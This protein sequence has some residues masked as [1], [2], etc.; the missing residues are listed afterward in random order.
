MGLDGGATLRTRHQRADGSLA[1]SFGPGPRGA[2]LR[3]LRQVSPLRA[4]FPTPEPGENPVV[5]VVNTAGGVAGGDRLSVDLRLQPGACVTVSTPAAEKVYRALDASA[6]IALRLDVGPGAVLE[7]IPQETILFSGARLRRRADI[8]LAPDARLVLTDS[9]VLGRAAMG[10]RFASGSVG[11]AW[12]LRRGGRL[13]WADGL[14]L[15]GDLAP[16]RGRFGFAGAEAY[17]TLLLAAPGAEV[18]LPALRAALDG[19]P[20]GPPCRAPGCSLPA[21]WAARPQSVVRSRRACSACVP[22]R[23]AFRPA[24]RGCGRREPIGT[25]MTA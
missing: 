2:A 6:E 9:L 11:D 14:R 21:S 24:C 10:E 7:W 19:A 18:H 22:R 12:R 17:A 25:G 13:L 15:D 5:A 1:L 3:D 23:S 8:S 16:L 4:L 20:G